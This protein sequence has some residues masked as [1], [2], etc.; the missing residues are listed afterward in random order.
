MAYSVELKDK[1]LLAIFSLDDALEAVGEYAGDELKRY[2]ASYYEVNLADVDD[3]EKIFD[4]MEQETEMRREHYRNMLLD[5]L[6]KTEPM[7]SLMNEK[8]LNREKMGEAVMQF[9]NRIRSELNK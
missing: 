1:K 9:S 8:Y 3:Y 5:L 7:T 4:Q 6:A 2:L